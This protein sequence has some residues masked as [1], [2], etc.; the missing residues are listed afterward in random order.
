MIQFL[1]ERSIAF[2]GSANHETIGDPKYGNFLGLAQLLAKF[3]PV[4]A[5]HL[6]KVNSNMISDHYLSITI[7][8]ELIELTGH[9]IVSEIVVN[10]QEA[11][12]Y[13]LILDCTPDV[14]HQEQ[15]I[16]ILRFVDIKKVVVRAF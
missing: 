6:S 11:K 10:L 16:V 14:S 4:M 15:L 13:S 3:D 7:Q 8:D 9:K 1:A 2:R 12:Y 5:E